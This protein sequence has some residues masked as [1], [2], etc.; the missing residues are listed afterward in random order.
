MSE[1]PVAPTSRICA[2]GKHKPT[3]H[4]QSVAKKGLH[5]SRF[6]IILSANQNGI[7]GVAPQ[8][9][10]INAGG[11]SHENAVN[12]FTRDEYPSTQK[13]EENR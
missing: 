12:E 13:V 2:T 10:N 6:L 4:Y 3:F 7:S 5:K 1:K 8:S 9:F 11:A